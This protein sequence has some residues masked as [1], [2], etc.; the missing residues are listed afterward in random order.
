LSSGGTESRLE[1]VCFKVP[2][3]KVNEYDERANDRRPMKPVREWLLSPEMAR[4][5]DN[6]QR[7]FSSSLQGAVRADCRYLIHRLTQWISDEQQRH[8]DNGIRRRR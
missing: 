5:V 4:N 7:Q 3:E 8:N 2:M 1:K 6:N